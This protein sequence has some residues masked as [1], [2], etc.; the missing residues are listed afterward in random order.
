MSY[1][2]DDH[3]AARRPRMVGRVRTVEL[4]LL[5]GL[6]DPAE[7]SEHLAADGRRVFLS[8]GV[9]RD[10]AELERREHP[11]ETA[12]LLFGGH[13]SDGRRA[14]TVVEKLVE[15]LPG[16]VLGTRSTVTITH[17]GS[18]SMLRRAAREDPVLAPV[19][20]AH[21]HPSFDAYFSEVDRSEQRAWRGAGSVGLVL[22]GLPHAR[23]RYRVFVGPE[24]THAP[25]VDSPDAAGEAHSTAQRHIEPPAREHEA[26]EANE[27]GEAARRTRRGW[28]TLHRGSGADSRRP[29]PRRR[30]AVAQRA[31][32]V[33]RGRALRT[34]RSDALRPVVVTRITVYTIVG[35]LLASLAISLYAVHLARERL[36]ESHPVT[37]L[38]RPQERGISGYERANP[39]L[40]VFSG[41]GLR[42]A[43]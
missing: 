36:Q 29:G 21:T 3:Q 43:K 27:H 9:L 25:A 28:K 38:N 19:G 30:G 1:L 18:E 4:P 23:P 15:P 34:F 33:Q 37:A 16:E 5:R 39:E 2:A 42:W 14:C 10:L 31:E 22:S 12:G 11:V 17:A 20:W 40:P 35:A 32:R 7:Y 26:N 41:V 13:F 6:P 24:S 8:K